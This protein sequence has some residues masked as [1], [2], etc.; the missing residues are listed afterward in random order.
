MRAAGASVNSRQL[1]IDGRARTRQTAPVAV[2]FR[3]ACLVAVTLLITV[4]CA[5]AP[6]APAPQAGSACSAGRAAHPQA[7][8]ADVRHRPARL[9]AVVRRRQARVRAGLRGRRRRR[10][11]RRPRLPQ[12]QGRLG[13]GAVQRGH[14]ARAQDL[15]PRPQRVL[16]HRR[17]QAGRR[18]LRALLRRQA[19]RDRAEDLHDRRGDVDRGA[20]VGASSARRSAPPASTRSPSQIAP[21]AKPSVFN[22]NDDAK[23]ALHQRP[24]R[25]P[26]GGPAHRVLH[27]LRGARRTPRSSASCRRASGTP[28]QFGAVLDKGSALTACVSQAVDKLRSAGT[29]ATL[30]K[31]WLSTAGS[32]PELDV[33]PSALAQ[34]RLA[35]RRSRARRSTAVAVGVD[36]GVRGRRRVRHHAHARAGPGCRR[37]SSPPPWP[38]RRCRRCCEGCGSTCGC[39]SS[40]RSGSCPRPRDRQRCAPCAARCSSRCARWRRA[41]STCSAA[42]RCSSRST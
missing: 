14:P 42:C 37:P 5:P 15:R 6:Q 21:T 40:R 25:R 32:A 16:D 39:S 10:D 4:G 41:T 26:R 12:G 29:L 33:T 31:Q 3:S 34:E 23:V 1:V 8:H 38:G 17:A 30:E 20:Q 9:P 7:G 13:A 22:S 24:G 36:A 11:R 28:E 18:L 27:H 2:T 19:G 35:Y